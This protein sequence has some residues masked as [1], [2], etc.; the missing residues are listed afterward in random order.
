[1][2]ND[3]DDDTYVAADCE[4]SGAKPEYA[5]QPWRYPKGDFW[6][7]SFVWVWREAGETKHAGTL[8]PD[9]LQIRDFLQWV[10]D[11]KKIVVGW[12]IVFDLGVLIAMGFR[13]QVY[14]IRWLDGMLVWRHLWLEPE[15]DMNRANKQSYSLKI[16]VPNFLPEY[17]GYEAEINYHGTEPE[18]LQKLHDYNI[19][20]TFF[21]LKITRM[22]YK[23]LKSKQRQSMWMETRCLPM[24]AEANV[25]GLPVDTI[26]SKEL[27]LK[28]GDNAEKALDILGPH[29]MTAEIV[30][31]PTKLA[32]LMFDQWQLP[33]LKTTKTKDRVTPTG[34]VIPG[35]I[36]R[37]TDKEVLY[38]LDAMGFKK[39]KVIREYRNALNNRFKFAE[40]LVESVEY[41]GDDRVHPL[42]HVFGTYTGRI[43]V[44]S[45]QKAKVTI[46]KHLK[47][48]TTEREGEIELPI[49]WAQHQMPGAKNG[50]AFREQ[51]IAPYGYD[52][53]E[54][55]AAGQEYK[56][57][58][59]ASG[60]KTMLMLSMPGEDPHSY[61]TANIYSED[62]RELQ[63][64]N[65]AG[66][67]VAGSKRKMGKIGNLSCLT[68]GT[69]ILTD[70]GPVSIEHIERADRVWDGVEFVSHS[71]VVDQGERWAVW[72]D[73][74][75][76]TPDHQVMVAGAWE[77]HDEAQRMGWT[78]DRACAPRDTVRIVGGLARR[79]I[80]KMWRALRDGAMRLWARAR[81]QSEVYGDR[82]IYTVQGLCFSGASPKGRSSDCNR[83]HNEAFA[84]A[85][86][87]MVSALS[88]HKGSILPK[89]W[90]AWDRVSL[91]ISVGRRG[92]YQTIPTSPDISETRH[93]STR[94]QWSL[95]AWKLAFGYSQ[96]EPRQSAQTHVYDIVDCGPRNRFSANGRIVHNCQYRTSAKRLRVTARVDYDV[97]MTQPEAD[98]IWGTYQ[99]T[100]RGVPQYWISQISRV[101]A[102]GYVET[103]AGRRVQIT[104]DWNGE[105]GWKMGSTAINYRIQGTGADQKYLA[106]SLLRDKLIEYDGYFAFDLHDGLYSFVPKDRSRAF[107]ADVKSLLDDL[108]YGP[109]WGFIPPVPM[110]W[111]CKIGPNW[112]ALKGF[113]P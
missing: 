23:Q 25:R 90:R 17:A 100:Y 104:G 47:T 43:T 92:L 35:K 87:R 18:E 33:V 9:W 46:V 37:S 75:M 84:E 34:K 36:N 76:A 63:R 1:M 24:V 21:T 89:L 109:M 12:N 59:V 99:R 55:D 94:Q 88:K 26:A 72:H 62:Y 83:C 111:D 95:R 27:A 45:K 5:L 28:L 2:V 70:R 6:L 110:N 50:K 106:M 98:L 74:N 80:R 57:M 73:G 103:M 4:T 68:A 44:S 67:D 105:W 16:A 51:V 93:R 61:M 58:A 101:R 69:M 107:A 49:G 60:D 38:E 71:G 11:N 40:R 85:R 66:D 8:F 32:E 102:V 29:G 54:F 53:V 19:K 65:D 108:P 15:Y 77:R 14:Q 56:W 30:A 42:M 112:G 81:S 31:S 79:A 22:L 52:M 78:V 10:I 64:L 97:P 82:T 20:D 41:N 48:K 13:E 96:D 91:R 39:P 113:K 86:Q 7:T 3:W